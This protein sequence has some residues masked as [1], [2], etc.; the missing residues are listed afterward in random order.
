MERTHR[1]PPRP[2]PWRDPTNG[3][4]ADAPLT[5]FEVEVNAVIAAARVLLDH[6][7]DT[8]NVRWSVEDTFDTLGVDPANERPIIDT[9]FVSRQ[10]A[11]Q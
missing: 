1:Y 2:Y 9:I 8:G 6:G 4:E 5:P 11:N 3:L 7:A 10:P